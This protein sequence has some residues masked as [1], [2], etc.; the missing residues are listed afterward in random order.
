VADNSKIQ[1]TDA[2]WTVVTGCTKDSAGCAHC[3]AAREWS[4]LSA[5]PAVPKY[6]GRS[7]GDVRFHVSDLDQPLRWRRP[8]RIF[9][10]SMGDLFHEQ[11]FDHQ[12]AAAF[13]VMAACPQHQFQVLTKRAS[14]MRAFMSDWDMNRCLYVLEQV[15]WD[16]SATVVAQM[17]WPP[18]NVLLGVSAEDQQTADARIGELLDT[19]AAGRFVSLEPLLAGVD[20]SDFLVPPGAPNRIVKPLSLPIE[21][22]PVVGVDWVIAGGESGPKARPTHPNAFRRLRDQCECAQVPFYFKQWGEWAPYAQAS[23]TG[24]RYAR[25]HVFSDGTAVYRC[26]KK[27]AGRVLDGRT[28]DEVPAGP[29]AARTAA[30]GE[31]AV[32]HRQDR[33]G[34]AP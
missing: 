22:M 21:Y 20:L 23:P 7:F 31:A 2:T 13:A 33:R 27:K 32:L 16:I 24:D 3:Y 25:T 6:Y 10:P 14:R 17:A 8:R 1:W 19:P 12:I 29:A 28:H 9:V 26:G 5:N 11:I 4:R 34:N 15:A 18:V 30:P